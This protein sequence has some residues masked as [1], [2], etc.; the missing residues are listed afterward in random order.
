VAAGPVAGWLGVAYAPS[1]TDAVH[2]RLLS[3]SPTMPKPL[4]S[5]GSTSCRTGGGEGGG[6]QKVAALVGLVVAG[7]CLLAPLPAHGRRAGRQ[8]GRQPAV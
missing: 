5:V 3:S 4:G 7:A 2:L 8:A 6:Q 1:P